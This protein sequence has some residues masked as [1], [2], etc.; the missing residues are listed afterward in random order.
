MK[1]GDLVR[2]NLGIFDLP[3]EIGIVTDVVTSSIDGAIYIEVTT[4][5]GVHRR[6]ASELEVICK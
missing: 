1:I 3:S 6:W 5:S 4:G 2:V